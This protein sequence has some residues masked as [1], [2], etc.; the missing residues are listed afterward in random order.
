MP[1]LSPLAQ[2]FTIPNEIK[3]PVYATSVDLYF[4]NVDVNETEPVLVDIVETLNGYPTQTVVPVS[5]AILFPEDIVASGAAKNFTTA[6]AAQLTYT[7][8]NFKFKGLVLLLPGVEY[9]VRVQTNSTKYRLW[10][11]RMGDERLDVKGSVVTKQ[12]AVGSFFKSQNGSTWTP[13]QTQDLTFNIKYASFDITK[14]GTLNLHE[15]AKNKIIKLSPNPFK[16]TNG[17]TKVKVHHINHGLKATYLVAFTG[18]DDSR[19]NHTFSVSTVVNNDYYVINL[20]SA[21]TATDNVGG[22][23]VNTEKS[24]QFDTMTISGVDVGSDIGVKMGALLSTWG[25][26]AAETFAY[27][28]MMIPLGENKFVHSSTNKL[29]STNGKP[30]FNTIF[31]I[32]SVKASTSPVIHLDSVACSVFKN[33]INNPSPLDVDYDI[34]VDLIIVGSSDVSFAAPNQIKI[35]AATAYHTYKIKLGAWLRISDAGG[36]NDLKE[37][38]IDSYD[39][40][41]NIIT[42]VTDTANEL[43]TQSNRSATINQFLSYVSET[44]PSGGTAESKYLTKQVTLKDLCTSFRVI[45]EANVPPACEFEVYYRSG[46]EDVTNKNWTLFPATYRKSIQENDFVEY[47]YDIQDL[48]KFSKFQFKIVMK[49]SNSAYTPKFRKFRIIT[50]A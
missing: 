29:A 6:S 37:G 40:L 14:I 43:V 21:A 49:S 30:S 47:E 1:N 35:P 10:T 9:A 19:F 5:Q 16:T 13:E 38:Y 32:S 42:L 12:P 20:A 44:A 50:T 31:K 2:T 23:Q 45:M 46:T 15:R 27:P 3:T 25:L 39:P 26:D 48:D 34:D 4:A 28:K 7:P 24:I 18:S 41:T 33:K 36:S 22:G 11:A 8:V 17:S